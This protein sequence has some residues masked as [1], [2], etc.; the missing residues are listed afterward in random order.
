MQGVKGT[1]AGRL[2]GTHSAFGTT[3]PLAPSRKLAARLATHPTPL[4]RPDARSLMRE[5]PATGPACS[6]YRRTSRSVARTTS[7]DTNT[8]R[9]SRVSCSSSRS[10]GDSSRSPPSSKLPLPLRERRRRPPPPRS[11]R[12]LRSRLRLRRRSRSRL[13]LR[14]GDR[15]R[16][17]LRPSTPSRGSGGGAAAADDDDD[18]G[19]GAAAAAA[20]AGSGLRLR[21]RRGGGERESPRRRRSRLRLRLAG[22]RLPPR[23]SRRSSRRSRLSRS[24]LRER[25]DRRRA[26]PSPG[27]TA[28]DA[29]RSAGARSA[30]VAVA[31]QESGM[32]HE[33]RHARVGL[34][35][36][37][38]KRAS[39]GTLNV[40]ESYIVKCYH[41]SKRQQNLVRARMR[42]PSGPLSH[43]ASGRRSILT[44]SPH[45]DPPPCPPVVLVS[46][47]PST[48]HTQVSTRSKTLRA[49]HAGVRGARQARPTTVAS[50][51]PSARPCRR[52][53]R[54]PC[55]S[56]DL[57]RRTAARVS[58]PSV[59][60]LSAEPAAAWRALLL[61]LLV[62]A[63]PPR[64]ALPPPLPA[65]CRSSRTP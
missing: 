59:A 27:D 43:P 56:G 34:R 31:A 61:T 58:A 25:D 48:T 46:C 19:T 17:E 44:A 15:R 64:D 63:P 16:L 39:P 5:T 50:G 18:D 33:A 21:G 42:W 10:S 28:R 37:S 53:L 11:S 9:A 60:W 55:A 38:G 51:L 8:V 3:R 14:L 35:P 4:E 29:A 65:E 23:S 2:A 12:L 45:A 6:K 57:I 52:S 22:R 24:R 49:R 13:R 7:C 1:P 32:L 26:A 47:Q 41:E 30:I 20:G 36:W 62:A 54:A 40:G